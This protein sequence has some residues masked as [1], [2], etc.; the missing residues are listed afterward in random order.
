MTHPVL[1]VFLDLEDTVIT[2]V[3]GPWSDAELLQHNIAQ[4]RTAL[5]ASDLVPDGTTTL[6]LFSFAL[7]NAHEL[8]EFNKHVRPRLE[9]ALGQRFFWTPT[10]DEEI[11]PAIA[12]VTNIHPTRLSFEDICHFYGKH[13]S[14]RLFIRDKFKHNTSPL[15]VVLLDDAVINEDFVFLDLKVEG[16]IRNID[17]MPT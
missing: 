2:P 10:I 7:W 13:E 17:H 16:S 11:L 9:E 12:R 3:V 4:I 6:H 5:Q 8:A 1:H 14:F 15:S